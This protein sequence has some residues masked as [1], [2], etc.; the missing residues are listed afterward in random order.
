MQL[1][2]RVHLR[3][4]PDYYSSDH[5]G[6]VRASHALTKHGFSHDYNSY[7]R[8]VC[9]SNHGIPLEFSIGASHYDVAH[10][11]DERGRHNYSHHHSERVLR[12]PATTRPTAGAS[13]HCSGK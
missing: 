8:A 6:A 1:I 3:L 13:L 9:L 10:D 7:Y 4:H 12:R 5:I 11:R 2:S